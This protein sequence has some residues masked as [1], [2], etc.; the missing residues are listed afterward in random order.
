MGKRVMLKIMATI[1]AFLLCTG[2]AGVYAMWVYPSSKA[3]LSAQ[4]LSLGMEVFVYAPEEVLPDTEEDTL[5]QT[6]HIHIVTELLFNDKM[7]LNGGKNALE[8][9]VEQHGLLHYLE[10]IQGGNLK[11]LIDVTEGGKNLGFVLEYIDESQFYC[12]TF[13]R[14]NQVAGARIPV[15]RTLLKS[16]SDTDVDEDGDGKTDKWIAY[17]SA[18]GNAVASQLSGSEYT[19]TPSTWVVGAIA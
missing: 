6:N 12:Y 10:N 7:G 2:V 3:E 13:Y 18:L 11:H 14:L 19:I 1:C 17:S 16:N 15:Y 8:N 9:A 5:A 4:P